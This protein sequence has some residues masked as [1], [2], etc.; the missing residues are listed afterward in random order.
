MAFNAEDAKDLFINEGCMIVFGLIYA[1]GELRQEMLGI[2]KRHYRSLDL[3]DSWKA[4]MLSYLRDAT[5]LIGPEASAKAQ[6]EI[7]RLHARMII[8]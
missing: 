8:N 1:D 6:E 3:A 5:R 7:K 2:T 4:A